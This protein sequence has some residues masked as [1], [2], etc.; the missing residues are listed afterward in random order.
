MLSI[1][2]AFKHT[3]YRKQPSDHLTLHHIKHTDCIDFPLC[4]TQCVFPTVC[5]VSFN[6]SAVVVELQ[7]KDY[8]KEVLQK[9]VQ[10]LLQTFRLYLSIWIYFTL[11]IGL[12][13]SNI[14]KRNI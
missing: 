10:V 4:V 3:S 14:N 1:P 5:N 9:G 7:D 12:F 8:E 6:H 13:E 2:Y 11:L